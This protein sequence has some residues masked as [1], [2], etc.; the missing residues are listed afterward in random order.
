MDHSGS[1]KA[2]L[3]ELELMMGAIKEGINFQKKEVA[4]LKSE[5]ETLESVLSMK[6]NE[7]RKTMIDDV[8]RTDK[9]MRDKFKLQKSENNKLQQQATMLKQEK[10]N[11]QQNIL[12]LQRR[13]GELEL[14]IG[15][16]EDH[17]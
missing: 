4:C 16:R 9:D 14:I 2:N 10:T 3:S 5:K 12:A 15:G 8:N 6:A 11:I 7:V 1:L 17:H 13:V